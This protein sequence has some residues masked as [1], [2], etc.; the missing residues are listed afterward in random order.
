M[1]ALQHS[2]V[3]V[4]DGQ[5]ASCVAQ[6]AVGATRMVH[7]VD[8]SGNQGGHLVNGIHALLFMG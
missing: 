3:I 1:V 6:E 8:G 7:I 2:G 5:L 4:E